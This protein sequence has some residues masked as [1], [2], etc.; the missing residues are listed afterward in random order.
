LIEIKYK[1]YCDKCGCF[2]A[3]LEK[4]NDKYGYCSGEGYKKG[5]TEYIHFNVFCSEVCKQ[6]YYKEKGAIEIFDYL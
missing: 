6:E 1:L 2:I 4:E 3:N 5:N